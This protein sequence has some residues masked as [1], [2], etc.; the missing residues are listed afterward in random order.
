MYCR[1]YESHC[2]VISDYG[3]SGCL[4]FNSQTEGSDYGENAVTGVLLDDAS[5]ADG[6]Y[7]QCLSLAE[8]NA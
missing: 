3:D 2:R 7:G 8:T 1:V 5:L 4:H 6:K